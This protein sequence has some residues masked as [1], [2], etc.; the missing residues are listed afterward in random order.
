MAFASKTSV[1]R[2]HGSRAWQ[3]TRDGVNTNH[4]DPSSKA[5]VGSLN[6]SSEADCQG[7]P[8]RHES[9]TTEKRKS[10]VVSK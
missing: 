1:L 10:E 8:L 3:H 2:G 4:L 5:N 7:V 6:Y 9:S